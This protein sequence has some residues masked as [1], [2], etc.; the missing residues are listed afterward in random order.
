MSYWSTTEV[1]EF[2]SVSP[3]T[4]RR[5]IRAGQLEARKAPSGR[6]AWRV[7]ASAVRDYRDI[8]AEEGEYNDAPRAAIYVRAPEGT[9]FGDRILVHL[10]QYATRNDYEVGEV[11][12]DTASGID[13]GR[14]RLAALRRCVLDGRVDVIV[15]ERLDRILLTGYR[16]FERWATAAKVRIEEAGVVNEEA[17]VCYAQEIVEDLF[18]PLADALALATDRT[19]A[20][21]ATARAL[22]DV[23]QFLG[24]DQPDTLPEI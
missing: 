8:R 3:S 1:A 9:D 6:G 14:E 7:P 15:V 11:I 21:Q 5:W 4:V 17:E 24:V 16:E 20:E 19:R 10:T 12:R 18:F 13:V 22:A 2:L 23:W